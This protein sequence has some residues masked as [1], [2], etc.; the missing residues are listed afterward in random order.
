VVPA[1]NPYL[2]GGALV[3]T[4]RAALRRIQDSSFVVEKALV[5]DLRSIRSFRNP[6]EIRMAVAIIV[7]MLRYLR[8]PAVLFETATPLAGEA[9]PECVDFTDVVVSIPVSSELPLNVT[10]TDT[11]TGRRHKWTEDL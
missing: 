4:V 11:R 6:V 1:G 7:A 9:E 2:D 3:D 10:M 5:G 8:I